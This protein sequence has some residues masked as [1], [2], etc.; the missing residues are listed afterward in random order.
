METFFR[1]A[2]LPGVAY[3]SRLEAAPTRICW[4]R[5]TYT[6]HAIKLHHETIILLPQVFRP[7]PWLRPNYHLLLVGCV[8]LGGETGYNHHGGHVQA[9]DGAQVTNILVTLFCVSCIFMHIIV[10]QV[11]HCDCLPGL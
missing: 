11:S 4:V 9:G 1:T 3:L 7:P 6:F 2:S 5:Q 8:G 10:S